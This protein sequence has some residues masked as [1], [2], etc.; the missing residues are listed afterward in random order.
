MIVS[1]DVGTSYSSICILGKDG[2]ALPVDISTGASMFGS[3]FSLPSAVYIEDDGTHLVGQAALNS[4]KRNPSNFFMEFK[5]L[6]GQEIPVVLGYR[7][8]FPEDMYTFIFRHM[9]ECARKMSGETIDRAYITYPAA[10]TQKQK[11][12]IIHAAA[13]AGLFETVLVDEPTAVAFNYKE[14]GYISNGQTVLIYDFGGG[15]FDASIVTM[16]NDQIVSAAH[17]RGLEHCGGIDMDRLIF[18]DMFNTIPEDI[19]NIIMSQERRRLRMEA[20]LSELAVKAKHHLSSATKFR[21]EIELGMDDCSYELDRSRFEMMIAP[22]I[23]QTLDVCR[24]LMKDAGIGH[25]QLSSVILAGGTSRIPL[26]QQMVGQFAKGVPVW[27]VK[28]LDLAIAMGALYAQRSGEQPASHTNREKDRYLKNP[29]QRICGNETT[30]AAIDDLGNVHSDDP[31]LNEWHNVVSIACG[32]EHFAALTVDG[33]VVARGDN[34][35]SQCNTRRWSDIIEVCCGALYTVGVKKDGTVVGVGRNES[36]QC[37][38][39]QWRN[40]KSIACGES[41]TAAIT[42]DGT[43]VACGKNNLG[44]CVIS[45]WKNVAEI[46]CGRDYT[47]GLCKDKRVAAAGD[48]SVAKSAGQW[49]DI[50]ALACAPLHM[51]GLKTDGTALA[52]GD[53][54]FGQCEVD[55]WS[56]LT[57]IVCGAGFTAGL[58]ENHTVVAVGDNRF[59]QCEVSDWKNIIGIAAGGNRLIGI[60]YDGTVIC[61]DYRY[62]R[63]NHYGISDSLIPVPAVTKVFPWKLF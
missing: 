28:D 25:S 44:Q 8:L 56:G 24:Y 52:C 11:L 41:H 34:V 54:S 1:I 39:K 35:F 3:K 17:P 63:R 48:P 57:A 7:K 14:A 55:S 15:T 6:L 51:A 38:F 18:Q 42:S 12:K 43:A 46:F 10:F 5:R 62:V 13:G 27:S 40:I 31:E 53:N 4:R 36:G 22:M 26:V 33:K 29:K 45:H 30:V 32:E 58:M 19:R 60:Q 59:G 37:S 47:A 9:T 16:E 50:A 61:T 49:T 20:Q 2:K 21:D 23:A